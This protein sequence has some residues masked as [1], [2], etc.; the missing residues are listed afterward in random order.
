VDGDL[1]FQPVTTGG[2]ALQGGVFVTLGGAANGPPDGELTESTKIYLC[3]TT[4]PATNVKVD[5]K[6]I[7]SNSLIWRGEFI[8]LAQCPA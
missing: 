6:H 8:S 7:G 4:G 3:A 2:D 5:V 1:D